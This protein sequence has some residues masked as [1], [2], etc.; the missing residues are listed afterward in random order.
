MNKGPAAAGCENI[1]GRRTVQA[2]AFALVYKM[3]FIFAPC[4]A[5]LSQKR[6]LNAAHFVG[7]PFVGDKN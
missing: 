1:C 5:A 6:G 3:G 4:H 2:K 7:I